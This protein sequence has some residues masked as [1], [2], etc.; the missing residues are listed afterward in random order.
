MHI[1]IILENGIIHDYLLKIQ[2]QTEQKTINTNKK[3]RE[4]ENKY[5]NSDH[6]ITARIDHW[7]YKV[8]NFCWKKKFVSNNTTRRVV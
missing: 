3:K 4:K 6:K 2:T 1:S 7:L 5:L 8:T